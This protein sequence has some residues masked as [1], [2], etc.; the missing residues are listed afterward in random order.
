MFMIDNLG[1]EN[2]LLY[3]YLRDH[4]NLMDKVQFKNQIGGQSWGKIVLHET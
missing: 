1:I 4:G 2:W 3:E